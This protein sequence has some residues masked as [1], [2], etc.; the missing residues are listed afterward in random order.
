MFVSC[1]K[2]AEQSGSQQRSS[3]AVMMLW[4]L[5]QMQRADTMSVYQPDPKSMSVVKRSDG[6][7]EVDKFGVYDGPYKAAIDAWTV[8]GKLKTELEERFAR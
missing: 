8:I 7:Y 4:P 6:W 3:A 5:S 1:D 2:L